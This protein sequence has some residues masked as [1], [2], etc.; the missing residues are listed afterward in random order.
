M[1]AAFCLPS[2]GLGDC[3]DEVSIEDRLRDS[4]L[5]GKL[6][7]F[8]CFWS[9]SIF[10]VSSLP[11]AQT[12]LPASKSACPGSV[13]AARLHN[14]LAVLPHEE[15]IGL[16]QGPRAIFSRQ[17][18]LVPATTKCCRSCAAWK[19]DDLP[20][21]VRSVA[22]FVTCSTS[23]L[24]SCAPSRRSVRPEAEKFGV[25]FDHLICASSV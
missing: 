1:R 17:R 4:R 6:R 12:K 10:I 18:H 9:R 20:L 14:A 15:F 16:D 8:S 7:A 24:P 21:L 13:R 25:S 11:A 5:P 22:R 3:F 23:A 2:Q 19:P